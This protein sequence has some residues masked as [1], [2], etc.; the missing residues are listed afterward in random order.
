MMLVATADPDN[1]PPSPTAAAPMQRD[2]VSDVRTPAGRCHS[3]HVTSDREWARFDDVRAGTALV[4]PEPERMLVARCADD[5][6]EVLEQVGRA[7]DDGAWAFGFV[8]YEAGAGLD[9]ALTVAGVPSGVPLAW[10]GVG[11]APREGPTVAARHAPREYWCSDWQLDA[12]PADHAYAL[13]HVQAEIAAGRIYQANLTTRARATVRGRLADLYADLVHAQ[14]GAYNALLQLDECAVISASPELFF[15]WTAAGIRCRPMK[16]TARRGRSPQADERAGEALSA[17]VK[18]VAENVMIADLVRNDLGRIARTGSVQVTELCAREAF[19]EVWQLSSQITCEPRPDTT[20]V[21]VFAALFPS[22]SITGAP[23]ASATKVIAA[24]EPH[25]RGIYCGA[26]GWVAPP[27]STT[28]ARFNVA[29][30]TLVVDQDTGA[31]SYG[32][33]GGI[34]IDSDPSGEYQE[35][36]DKTAVLTAIAADSELE[37]I[38][39]LA[40]VR[41][42]GYRNL[43]RHVERLARSAEYFGFRYCEHEVRDALRRAIDGHRSARVRIALGREGFVQVT[44]SELPTPASAPVRVALDRCAVDAGSIWQRHK[45]NRRAVYERARAG[46]PHADDVIMVNRYGAIAEST[47][48]NVAV[49]ADGHWWTPP[50]ESGCLPG[51]GRAVALEQ[52]RVTERDI[53]VAELRGCD[54][55]ALISSLRGWRSASLIG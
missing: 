35:M 51:I 39:T 25:P 18:D 50:L 20:L 8:T 29:I 19:G 14:R 6:A 28:R 1:S 11:R 53:T 22:G 45:T 13:R 23:K 44:V 43:D 30:R 38:E 32:T 5:V 31:A 55:I 24:V 9:S 27:A 33:G 46:H 2:S 40:F 49:R 48:A 10:F 34:T 47:V 36:L 26:I 54:A 42:T 4:F 41:P 15:E 16:G 17:S 21:D 37:L 12:T 52:G 7:T 3:V